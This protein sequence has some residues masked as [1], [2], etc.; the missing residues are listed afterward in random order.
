MLTSLPLPYHNKRSPA[1]SGDE[2]PFLGDELQNRGRAAHRQGAGG[3]TKAAALC[4]A[5]RR[6]D[7]IIGPYAEGRHPQGVRRT[8]AP[9]PAARMPCIVGR[10]FTPAGEGSRRPERVLVRP[11]TAPLSRLAPTAPLTGEPFRRQFSQSLPCKGL[12]SRAPPAAEKAVSHAANGRHSF[13][14][15][16]FG[17]RK[18]RIA[19]SPA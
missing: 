8:A 16:L 1:H 15:R 3:N 13:Y 6:A 12:R 19:L 10:A 9:G 11:C 18:H 2:L 7:E 14:Y 17:D 4:Q 5:R